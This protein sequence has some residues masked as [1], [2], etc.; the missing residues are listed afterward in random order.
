MEVK[1]KETN[2]RNSMLKRSI[3]ATDPGSGDCCPRSFW[4]RRSLGTQR[5]AQGV[6][7]GEVS[8]DLVGA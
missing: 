5:C 1:L 3:Q 8:S 6:A 4:R 2:V 7:G